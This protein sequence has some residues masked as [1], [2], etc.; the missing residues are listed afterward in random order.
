MDQ[1][2][3][4]NTIM[5]IE[6]QIGIGTGFCSVRDSCKVVP[7][8]TPFCNVRVWKIARRLQLLR[9]TSTPR[10]NNWGAQ[11]NFLIKGGIVSRRAINLIFWQYFQADCILERHAIDPS[12]LTEIF[13]YG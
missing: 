7:L 8:I 11:N 6:I 5:R 10:L 9:V 4:L 2:K 3:T 12:K 1:L 13:T